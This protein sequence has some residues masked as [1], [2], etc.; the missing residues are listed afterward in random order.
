METGYLIP[1]GFEDAV[2]GTVEQCGM[3]AKPLLDRAKCIEILEKDMSHE[4][5]IEFFE[6]NILG[7]YVG[8]DTPYFANLE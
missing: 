8:Q 1:T 7:A 3:S 5:A 6:Y 4:D 2:I